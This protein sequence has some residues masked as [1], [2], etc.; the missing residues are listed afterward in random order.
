MSKHVIKNYSTVLNSLKTAIKQARLKSVLT[1]NTQ[2][3]QLYWQ[4][5]NTIHKQ[6]RAKGWGTKIV[7]ILANDLS[8]AFPDMKGFSLRNLRYMREF[9]VAYPH[10][11]ILQAPLAK[12]E[13][14]SKNNH[15]LI[16]QAPLA[17][18]A[19]YHHITLLDKGVVKNKS[20]K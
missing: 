12:L 2:L 4:I 9:A 15:R 17:K 14:I 16:L 5:G 7:E 13:N 8:A 10:F 20:R 6:E 11:P 19:W 3:L 1:V 18:V